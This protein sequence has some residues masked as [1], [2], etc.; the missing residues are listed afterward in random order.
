MS[1][2]HPTPREW[3]GEGWWESMSPEIYHAVGGASGSRLN[4]LAETPAHLRADL[5]RRQQ[6]PKK[7]AFKVGTAVHEAVFEPTAFEEHYGFVAGDW[8]KKENREEVAE[9][10]EEKGGEEYVLKEDDWTMCLRVRDNVLAHPALQ[11]IT[12]GRDSAVCERSGFVWVDVDG[13]LVPMKGRLDFFPPGSSAILDLK[14]TTPGLSAWDW[15]R[16]CQR[17]GYHRKAAAHLIVAELLGEKPT[18]Y[19]HIAVEKRPPYG[20]RLFELAPSMLA[21]GWREVQALLRIY[22]RAVR[23]DIWPGYPPTRTTVELPPYY[24]SPESVAD[25]LDYY[26]DYYTNHED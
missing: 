2:K 23:T 3:P 20:V 22:D 18:E 21:T 12:R 8:R 26:L 5:D 17:R 4:K 6:A 9:I 16:E 24:D 10:A 1:R 19:V 11:G 7:K 25:H 15:G 14:S 13:V